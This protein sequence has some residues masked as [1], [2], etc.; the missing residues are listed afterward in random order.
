M[1]AGLKVNAGRPMVKHSRFGAMSGIPGCQLQC[2]HDGCAG[3]AQQVHHKILQCCMY[4]GSS[5][6]FHSQSEVELRLTWTG[7]KTSVV[8]R[9]KFSSLR[10]SSRG[11]K[12][13]V[14]LMA[15]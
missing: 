14:G 10:I 8:T 13:A 15:P 9:S 6:T 4:F 3:G 2:S 5:C 7:P 12:T 1:E 11:T